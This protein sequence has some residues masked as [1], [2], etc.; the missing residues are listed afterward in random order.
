MEG[1][2]IAK[3]RARIAQE[4]HAAQVG[5]TG[6]AQGTAQHRSII[7]R[8]ERMTQTLIR[9]QGYEQGMQIMM[10]HLEREEV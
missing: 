3:L 4:E 9:K 5:L 7:T 10:H 2:E 8:M 6:L 1:S